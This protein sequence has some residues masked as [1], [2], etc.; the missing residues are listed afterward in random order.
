MSLRGIVKGFFNFVRGCFIL[1]VCLLLML[2]VVVAIF[3]NSA[4][5]LVGSLSAAQLAGT[6]P[7]SAFAGY[8][9]IVALT[10]GANLLAGA[11]AGNGFPAYVTNS[12]SP[13]I[14]LPESHKSGVSA[15]KLDV[16]VATC[17]W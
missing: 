9:S 12:D 4:S 7:A 3:A 16:D 1:L 2:V 5:N 6:L 8:T 17:I 11:F 15:R 10:N 13:D 14:T